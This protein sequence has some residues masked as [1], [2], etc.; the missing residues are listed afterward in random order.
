M[1]FQEI[2]VGGL[3]FWFCGTKEV[4]PIGRQLGFW[5]GR[6]YGSWMMMKDVME[7]ES[8]KTKELLASKEFRE[9]WQNTKKVFEEWQTLQR[10]VQDLRH[11]LT[12]Q[13]P[14]KQWLWSQT[15]TLNAPHRK[16]PLN[17]PPSDTILSQLKESSERFEN[18]SKT[19]DQD[20]FLLAQTLFE[21]KSEK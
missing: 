16:P 7:Q 5:M 8:S 17:L 6:A 10:E 20:A 12:V 19:P 18:A 9:E 15:S 4:L 3:I 11:S 14:M 13:N 2:L 1:Y 21:L